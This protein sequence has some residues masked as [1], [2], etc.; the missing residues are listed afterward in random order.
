[1]KQGGSIPKEHD[2]TKGNER[3]GKW[4]SSSCW[5]KGSPA[6]RNSMLRE[7][8]N[9]TGRDLGHG[10]SIG[11]EGVARAGPRSS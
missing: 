9:T 8:G 3:A 5:L 1:M 4:S 7:E 2:D 11:K 6:P 10:A